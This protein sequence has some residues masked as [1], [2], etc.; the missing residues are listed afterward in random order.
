MDVG[1]AVSEIEE[2][3]GVSEEESAAG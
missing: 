2:A 3:G 1:G